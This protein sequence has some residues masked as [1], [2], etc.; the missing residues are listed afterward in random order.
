MRRYV[1]LLPGVPAPIGGFRLA[2]SHARMLAKHHEVTVAHVNANM[3]SR[4]IPSTYF[5][6]LKHVRARTLNQHRNYGRDE[7][8]FHVKYYHSSLPRL[9][10]DTI[11]VVCSWQ[12]MS[13]ISDEIFSEYKILHLAMD[14]P[15]FMG[16][17][18]E[19]LE[20]WSKKCKYIAISRHLH[21]EISSVRSS[22]FDVV[23]FPAIVEFTDPAE[24][25]SAYGDAV[26]RD[27]V[28]ANVATGRYKNFD[29]MVALLNVLSESV[30]VKAFGRNQRPS[31]LRPQIMYLEA[32]SDGKIRELYAGSTAVVGMSDFEGFGLPV[33]EGMCNGAA[34]F[35]T[36]N[37]GCRDYCDLDTDSKLLSKTNIDENAEVILRGIAD[38]DQLDQQRSHAKRNISKFFSTHTEAE[39][40]EIY[41]SL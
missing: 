5:N 13:I 1:F 40:L 3:G 6:I 17:E 33:L 26:F 14:Y 37:Y 10:K 18:A 8:G 30:N 39:L 12:L 7:F 34:A 31:T 22:D 2:Y 9:S 23:Y 36:D 21:S 29:N 41:E 20:S 27:G 28:V 11:Y 32:P 38:Q 4:Y 19:I 15:P 24:I 16:P 35:S 25:S